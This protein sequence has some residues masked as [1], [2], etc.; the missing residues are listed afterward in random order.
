MSSK[1]WVLLSSFAQQSSIMYMRGIL[2]DW[3]DCENC[4]LQLWNALH[5]L[6]TLQLCHAITLLLN[7]QLPSK[8]HGKTMYLVHNQ[9]QF[10]GTAH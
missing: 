4:E 1:F 5:M 9:S 3:F 7:T 8:L 6:H 2:H 10:N